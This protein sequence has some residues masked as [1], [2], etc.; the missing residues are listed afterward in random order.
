MI[1]ELDSNNR[2]CCISIMLGIKH[3]MENMRKKEGNGGECERK[4]MKTEEI[5]MENEGAGGRWRT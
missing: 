1:I 3:D 4:M 5:G 2:I